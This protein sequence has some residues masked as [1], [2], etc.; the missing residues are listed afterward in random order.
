MSKE[1]QKESANI[2]Y[3]TDD[4]IVLEKATAGDS[5][6][7]VI[8]AKNYYLLL[9]FTAGDFSVMKTGI[10]LKSIAKTIGEI[11]E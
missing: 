5:E 11:S 6:F 8:D 10:D 1:K 4:I 7:Y 2:I 3:M 9:S